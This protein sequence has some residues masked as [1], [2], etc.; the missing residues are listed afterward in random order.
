VSSAPRV[1]VKPDS[2]VE[3]A[4]AAPVTVTSLNVALPVASI[5][6]PFDPAPSIV[7]V[8]KSTFVIDWSK[9]ARIPWYVLRPLR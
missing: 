4:V 2:T 1:T 5:S 9:L 7:T 6:M 3:A 8:S